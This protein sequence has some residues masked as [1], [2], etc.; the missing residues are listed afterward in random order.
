[1]WYNTKLKV[2]EDGCFAAPSK[3]AIKKAQRC[4]KITINEFR[5][6]HPFLFALADY[7]SEDDPV[8]WVGRFEHPQKVD[9]VDIPRQEL[10]D[11]GSS[12]GSVAE[13]LPSA[14]ENQQN[15]SEE[16]QRSGGSDLTRINFNK[17]KKSNQIK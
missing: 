10:P 8:Q 5:I 17:K 15:L 1:M 12:A 3:K 6:D 11:C 9:I 7:G 16:Q 13:S 14:P 4:G 2:R